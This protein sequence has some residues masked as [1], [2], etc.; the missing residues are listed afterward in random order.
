[1]RIYYSLTTVDPVILSQTTA[2]TNNHECLDYIPGSTMLGAL[3]AQLY[4]SLD[5]QSSWAIFHSGAVQF[6]PSYPVVDQ[7]LALPIPACW[8]FEKDKK[9]FDG[10]KLNQAELVNQAHPNFE[11]AE[12]V[13]YK[14]CRNGYINSSGE[15]ASVGQGLSV[16]TA[17]NRETG[18]A[19]DGSL[20][21]YAYL[22]AKQTFIGW[23]ESDNLD[24]LDQI[25]TQLCGQFRLG[26]SRNTEFGRVDIQLLNDM[27]I[28]S[29]KVMNDVLTIWC[30]SD[31]QCLDS[32]G[33]ATFVPELNQLIPGVQGTLDANKSFIRPAKVSRFNQKRQGLDSE[34]LLISKGSVLVYRLDEPLSAQRL[35]DLQQSGIGINRQQG[36]GW[37]MVN[38]DWAEN[39]HLTDASLFDRVSLT[40]NAEPEYSNAPTSNLT[41]WIAN[42]CKEEND[43]AQIK[44]EVK[45]LLTQIGQAY[46]NARQYNHILNS[47]EV[48]PSSSQW[49]RISDEL[50]NHNHD[51]QTVLFDK[52][53]G[54]CKA[55]N[56]E[57]GWGIS[58][59]N[60]QGLITFA[61]FIQITLSNQSDKLALALLSR[62]NRYDFSTFIGLKKAA[63][64]LNFTLIDQPTTQSEAQS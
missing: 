15:T 63:Q 36:L 62:I 41:R 42:R 50:R 20:F 7:Q 5:E 29:P 53:H 9:A 3:A 51:W 61:D 18:I 56:D 6:G 22:E 43:A 8:H 49:R 54:I 23:V 32:L 45:A 1:M 31:C 46:R 28:S 64:E 25:K 11:R 40:A 12:G 52:N 30:L 4:S 35:N 55:Q 38:P 10:N 48:G 58:W 26:R 24:Y 60:G 57:L 47:Y 39:A 37:V 21:S 44:D 13:Q 33:L 14:Q 34:Q 59:D 27:P 2:T 19:K 16:K 17:I